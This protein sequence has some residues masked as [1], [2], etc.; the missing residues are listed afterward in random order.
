LVGCSMGPNELASFHCAPKGSQSIQVAKTR[1]VK[2]EPN[3]R[4]GSLADIAA[5]LPNVRVT[6]QKQTSPKKRCLISA[7]C[8]IQTLS[9]VASAGNGRQL[10]IVT[11]PDVFV[12]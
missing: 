10:K 1:L 8:Q 2:G 3:V 5:A 4:Y 11:H 9:E 6:L 7:K 12:R